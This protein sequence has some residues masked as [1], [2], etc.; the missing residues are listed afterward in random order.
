MTKLIEAVIFDFDGVVLD[1]ETP[2]Y[3]AHRR[4]YERCGAVLTV[5]EWCDAIGIW[6]EGHD[7]RRFATL[8][9]R[10]PHAPAR[11]PDHAERKRN[12]TAPP[13][14]HPQRGNHAQPPDPTPPP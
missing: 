10:S 4:I 6:T 12:F 7:D 2:E 14:R 1:S 3:E 11:A 9:E 8:C 5:D 13:P